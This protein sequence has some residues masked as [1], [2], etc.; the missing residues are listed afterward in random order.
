M[1]GRPDAPA[2]SIEAGIAAAIRRERDARGWSLAA[3]AERS[4]VSKAMLSKIELGQSSPTA[5]LLGRVCAG[6][7]IT[8][9]V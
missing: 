7:G 2:D 8:M 5:G 1:D 4:G 6:L 3:L 9:S